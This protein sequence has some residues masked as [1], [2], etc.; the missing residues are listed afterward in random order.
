M[1]KFAYF[2]HSL[3]ATKK[4][5]QRTYVP[6]IPACRSECTKSTGKSH[7]ILKK[8]TNQTADNISSKMARERK[9]VYEGSGQGQGGGP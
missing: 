3:Q 9:S 7:L 1:K 4:W 8:W 2:E 5:N 6:Y